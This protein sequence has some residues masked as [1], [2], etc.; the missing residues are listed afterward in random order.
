[1][2]LPLVL[3]G[4]FGV[5][6]HERSA[7]QA[8]AV[9][10]EVMEGVEDVARLQDHLR[11]AE[12]AAEELA[13]TLDGAAQRRFID[14]GRAIDALWP[15][16]QALND[17]HEHELL[18]DARAAWER[19]RRQAPDGSAR[20][21]DERRRR[22]AAD[23]A[24][25]Q[26]DTRKIL[27]HVL[28]HLERHE[29]AADASR[30]ERL[31]VVAVLLGLAALTALAISTAL[32][33]GVATPL[34][35]LR[36]AADALGAGDLS[37]RVPAE[38]LEEVRVVSAAFN[39]MADQLVA[40]RRRLADQ[41]EKD[42][43]TGLANRR[44][45]LERTEEEL[46][47]GAPAV[48]FI[49]LDDFKT[50]NDS[51]G[52]AVGDTLLVEVAGRLAQALRPGDSVARLGGDEF[53]VLLAGH[54]SAA[55][56]GRVADR[57]RLAL[58]A[59]VSVAGHTLQVRAS[60]G[61]A[62]AG[63]DDDA[64]TLLRN[65]DI[66]MYEAK[67]AG[68][69]ARRTYA[70]E[71]H[72]RAAGRLA[73]DTDLRRALDADALELHYQPVVDLTTGRLR[74]MEALVRWTHPERG[75]VSPAEFIPVAEE[76]GLIV[77]LGAWV[78]ER[79][80]RF[81]ARFGADLS[82]PLRVGVNVSPRQLET[83]GFVDEVRRCLT[84]TGL[85]PDRLILEITETTVARDP[86]ASAVILARLRA[87]GIAVAI[88]DFGAGYSSLG[89]LRRFPVDIIKIDRAFVS[90]LASEDGCDRTLIRAILALGEALGAGVLAEG[91]ENEE[92]ADALRQLGCVSAQGYHL[93]RPLPEAAAERYALERAGLGAGAAPSA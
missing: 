34:A 92:Q 21:R 2:I 19:A 88:D 25:A 73:L 42:H 55:T 3:L 36:R 69:D 16:L 62:R 40:G 93:S 67:A 91:V 48:L 11:A 56:A 77:P 58:A 78:L 30:R 15:E 43:L 59:P 89:V 37:H 47:A 52:H 44:V 72:A 18:A 83:P 85:A 38:G 84:T 57:L 6:A 32:R 28:Q 29:R 1:M 41:A 63:D 33:R 45:F 17:H 70:P 76:T 54:P 80:C 23:M 12:H 61:V 39:A 82:P 68:K 24:V 81:A 87:L 13:A 31:T 79:A 71:M 65:A 74:G 90:D 35:R 26:D 64:T 49:D 50:F 20:W 60:V 8:A 53:A 75:P 46:R 66:A 5:A 22:F 86:E 51:L 4:A 14:A 9:S 7:Q 10:V 27:G